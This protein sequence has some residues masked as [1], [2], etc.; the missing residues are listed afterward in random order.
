MNK[1]ACVTPWGTIR[2]G[3]YFDFLPEDERR[4]VL[5]HERGHL[6]HRHVLKR[7]L[8][9]VRHG[10]KGF[11]EMCEA[12]ELEADSYA[13]DKGHGPALARFISKHVKMTALG[14]PS[15]IRRLENLNG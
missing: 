11:Y 15:V 8:W 9:I 12:Q 3:E 5:A 13:R 2:T 10:F 7:V 14:Y 4:A 6:H 1:F